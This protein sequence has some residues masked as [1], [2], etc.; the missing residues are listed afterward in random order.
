ASFEERRLDLARRFAQVDDVLGD[1]PWFAGASFLLVDAVFAPIFRYFD[2]FDAIGVASV[3][4]GLE[5]VPA[6][7]KRLAARA[8]VA[9]AVTADYPARLREFL[10]RRPSHIATLIAAPQMERATLA[11]ALA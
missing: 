8:S 1:G 6:W 11:V 7:R 9:S 4:A 3:F 5:K 2:V 10:A